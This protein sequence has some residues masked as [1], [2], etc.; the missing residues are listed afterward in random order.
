[1][2]SP[3]S[4]VSEADLLVVLALLILDLSFELLHS[5]TGDALALYGGLGLQVMLLH[6]LHILSLHTNAAGGLDGSERVWVGLD[7]SG[8]FWV[9]LDVS[10]WVW[11][12]TTVAESSLGHSSPVHRLGYMQGQAMS[13][14]PV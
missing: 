8:C 1:M 10:G 7:G 3:E 9:G 12:L 6:P 11:M 13:K 5:S 4:D 14:H 2:W